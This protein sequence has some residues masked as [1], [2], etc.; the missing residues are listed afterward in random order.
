L[1]DGPRPRAFSD[2]LVG[3]GPPNCQSPEAHSQ[4]NCHLSPTISFLCATPP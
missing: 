4:F 3:K 1:A 2:E